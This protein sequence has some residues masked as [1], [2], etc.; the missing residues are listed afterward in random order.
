M[1]LFDTLLLNFFCIIGPLLLYAT[2]IFYNKKM[3]KKN[4]KLIFNLSLLVILYLLMEFYKLNSSLIFTAIIMIPIMISY[5][6]NNLISVFILS[7]IEIFVLNKL[8]QFNIYLLLIEYILYLIIYLL[9]YKK[10]LSFIMIIINTIFIVINLNFVNTETIIILS[11][12]TYLLYNFIIILMNNVE[13]ILKY[14]ISIKEFEKEK[15][16]RDSL[17]KI[18]HEIKNPMAVCKGYFDMMDINNDKQVKKYLPIIKD[19]I[20]HTLLILQ[21]FLSITKIRIEKETMDINMLLEEV[22]NSFKPIFKSKKIK[23]TINLVDDEIFINGDYNRLKQ[24]LINIIK[25]SVESILNP[26]GIVDIKA[27]VINNRYEIKIKDNGIGMNEETLSH[28]Y[29]PFHTTKNNGTGLGVVLSTEIIKKHSGTIEYI[30][31]PNYGTTVTI[32]LPI[33]KREN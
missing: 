3:N 16:V 12:V 30:S 22:N 7:A 11:L 25:N 23:E 18:A 6:K 32:T 20:D 1:N 8:V 4:D 19:E 10:H 14:H 29:E 2:Y 27:Q 9:G 31:K 15:Q 5:N 24:V 26:K 33:E 21:D 17:F 13:K 28:I